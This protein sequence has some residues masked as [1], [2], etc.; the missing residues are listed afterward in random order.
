MLPIRA[1]QI[2]RDYSRPMTKPN[3]RKSKPI[4]ST[5]RL[6]TLI[7]Q[8][9]MLSAEYKLHYI[10]VLNNIEKTEWYYTYNFI[11]HYGVE[12]YDHR[13]FFEYGSKYHPNNVQEIDGISEAI[14][15]N[16]FFYN[17]W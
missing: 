9:R 17:E 16:R 5:Y 10:M 3:W 15:K 2:I 14:I 4:I 11:Q 13:H 7:R 8:R 12:V 6:Y 1:L